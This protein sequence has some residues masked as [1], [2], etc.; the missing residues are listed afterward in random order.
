M[1]FAVVADEVRSLAQRS[2]QA[3]KDTS[4][5][6][7]ESIAKSNEGSTRLERV[8]EVIRAITEST[9]KV[10]TLV[11]EVNLGSQE[12]AR[13]IEQ[14]SK[15]I[16]QMDQVTQGTAASAEE[17][18]SASQQLSAQAEAMGHAVRKL[19]RM[20]GDTSEAHARP[21][22]AGRAPVISKPKPMST[23]ASA[24]PG[25]RA[26]RPVSK[27]ASLQHAALPESPTDAQFL[28]SFEE[29]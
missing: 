13:G 25:L 15:A 29:M 9:V 27:P 16:A 19:S 3:A 10:K 22:V 17:G 8:S 6:I 4:A 5:L 21:A 14:I 18:A 23:R 2:A 1:G 28:E 24:S 20:V 7:A 12:Q 11:D 26:P